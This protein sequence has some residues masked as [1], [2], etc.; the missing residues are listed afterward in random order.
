MCSSRITFIRFCAIC[1]GNGSPSGIS[2][3][4]WKHWASTLIAAKIW[5]CS[6][7]SSGTRSSRAI[8]QQYRDRDRVL[9][10]VTLDPALEDILSA[11]IEYGRTGPHDQA[12]TTGSEAVTRGIAAQLE[13]LT[14]AGFRLSC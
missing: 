14:G 9:R 10:V 12:V 11:G 5:V 7:S 6:P 8:C 2:R 13:N 3:Q 1:C 4:F